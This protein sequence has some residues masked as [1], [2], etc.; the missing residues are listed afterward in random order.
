MLREASAKIPAA[1]PSGTSRNPIV[2]FVFAVRG[3]PVRAL[4][5]L[6][7]A[8]A[9]NWPYSTGYMMVWSPAFPEARKTERFKALMR[10]VGLVDYWRAKGWPNACHPVGTDDFAC[11]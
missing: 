10:K 7:Y 9:T 8:I 3:A 4:D 2:H 1:Q 6:D 5:T 11:E